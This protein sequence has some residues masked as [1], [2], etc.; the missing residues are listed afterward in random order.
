L[1][2]SNNCIKKK[3]EKLKLKLIF[4]LKDQWKMGTYPLL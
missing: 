2:K 3:Q 4:S 1:R